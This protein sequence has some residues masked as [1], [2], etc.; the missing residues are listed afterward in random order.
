MRLVIV[1]TISFLLTSCSIIYSGVV[2]NNYA[3]QVSVS[4]IKG[5]RGNTNIGPNE[6]TEV[7]IFETES[8]TCISVSSNGETKFYHVP[9]P[10]KWS[11]ISGIWDVKFG[12]SVSPQGAFYVGQNGKTQQLNEVANCDT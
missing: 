2:K 11:K 10:P 9:S 5:V 1:L 4:S 12:L 6:N 8:G 3:Q 7:P